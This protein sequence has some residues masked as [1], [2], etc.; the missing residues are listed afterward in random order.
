MENTQALRTLDVATLRG[1]Q[2]VAIDSILS[3]QDVLC[4]FP[5]GTGK[6]VVFEVSALCSSNVTIVVSPLLG[7]LQQQS[8]KLAPH[9]VAVLEA[10]NGK[11]WKQGEGHVK[12][13]Y[14]TAEQLTQQ[15]ALRRHID[16]KNMIIDRN[17][18]DEAHVVLQWD[19][20]RR[21]SNT[22]LE[23]VVVI[24]DPKFTVLHHDVVP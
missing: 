6:T 3:G 4:T 19:N 22:L 24:H 9:G 15:S 23:I 1:K 2:Q 12:L 8:N 11:V 10:W 18:V 21:E 14:T 7:L 16:A 17:V 13:V 5:T 20:F